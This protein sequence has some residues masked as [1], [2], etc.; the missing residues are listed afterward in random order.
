MVTLLLAHDDA[1]QEPLLYLSLYFKTHRTHYYQL[2]Q[3]VREK[4][5]WIPWLTFFLEGVHETSNQ[6]AS[7]AKE[8]VELFDT[9]RRKIKSLGRAARSV[10]LVHD[11]FQ[12][13]PIASVARVSQSIENMSTPT[14]RK[15]INY[16][17][18]LGILNES[19]GKKRNQLF[20]H[21]EYLRILQRGT[22]PL[23]G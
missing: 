15:S 11:Y 18:E 16:L 20:T 2:L 19:T 8:L 23:L 1:L 5:E 9:D 22:E 14:I 6:A 13:R 12:S 4:G 10:Y 3:N 21:T 7:T 17:V